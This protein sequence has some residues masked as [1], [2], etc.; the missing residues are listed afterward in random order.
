MFVKD[1]SGAGWDED[2]Q[3]VILPDKVWAS[4][5]ESYQRFRYETLANWKELE[6]IFEGRIAT[7]KFASSGRVSLT[8]EENEEDDITFESDIITLDSA[9]TPIQ[10]GIQPGRVSNARAPAVTVVHRVTGRQPFV[11]PSKVKPKPAKPAD[12]I[13]SALSSL[14]EVWRKP[15]PAPAPG[16]GSG[17]EDVHSISARAG[18]LFRENYSAGLDIHDRLHI[19][20]L[21]ENNIKAN[22]FLHRLKFDDEREA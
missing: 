14:A 21:F 3:T 5:D 16:P 20:D 11:P 13:A 8:Q 1:L 22:F 6:Q 2:L 7:G 9:I 15:E 12:Q 17:L 4:L 19:F 10:R 18:A